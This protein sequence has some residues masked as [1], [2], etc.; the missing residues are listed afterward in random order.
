MTKGEIIDIQRRIG[1]TPDGIWGPKSAAACKAYV[2]S[3]M[4]SPN[5]WPKA[6]DA[7]MIAFYGQPGDEK[8]LVAL[9]V[10]GLGVRYGGKPVATIRCHDRV[11]DSLLAVL[12]EISQGPAAWVLGEY[13]GCFNHRPMRGSKTGRLSKHSWGAA[14]DLAPATN[15]LRTAWPT[16]STMPLAVIEAFAKRGWLSA[17]VEWG[18]DGMHFE[19]SRV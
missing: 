11:A 5:P 16:G 15:G 1:T 13:A 17:G 3:L 8:R 6:D 4:P 10:S 12:T 2:R 7:S 14:I 19:S 18:R 9:K